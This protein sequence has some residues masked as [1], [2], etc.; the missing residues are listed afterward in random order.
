M[1][2]L[3][4]EPSNDFHRVLKK[5]WVLLTIACCWAYKTGE[6]RHTQFGLIMFDK[7]YEM[8]S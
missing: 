7:I 2:N 5:L 1:V 4:S 8:A 3:K 6:W